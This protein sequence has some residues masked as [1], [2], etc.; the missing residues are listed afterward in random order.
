MA[1]WDEG[2]RTVNAQSLSR[3]NPRHHSCGHSAIHPQPQTKQK[4]RCGRPPPWKRRSSQSL[5]DIRVLESSALRRRAAISRL[6]P[7]DH[8]RRPHSWREKKC[9]QQRHFGCCCRHAAP[10]LVVAWTPPPA[11][12]QFIWDRARL[13]QPASR[14][15]CATTASSVKSTHSIQSVL[16]AHH[17]CCPLSCSAAPQ[18]GGFSACGHSCVD[19][20]PS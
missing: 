4:L 19:K 9:K 8:D 17:R 20:V 10:L 11:H 12:H 2:S 1:W 14:C 15:R 13:Q 5:P 7:T 6:P 18:R 3:M 16:S